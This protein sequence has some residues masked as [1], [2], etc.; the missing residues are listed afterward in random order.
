MCEQLKRKMNWIYRYF[1]H[2][3]IIKFIGFEAIHYIINLD[4]TSY[5]KYFSKFD[6]HISIRCIRSL[7]Q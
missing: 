1:T 7:N 2:Y 6:S 5:F 4:V 3:R